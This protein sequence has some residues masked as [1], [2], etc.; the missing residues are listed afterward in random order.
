MSTTSGIDAAREY[1][2]NHSAVDE[3]NNSAPGDPANTSPMSGYSVRLPTEVL[4]QAR[5]LAAE[6]G[7]TTGAWLREAIEKQ[8]AAANRDQAEQSATTTAFSQSEFSEL[9]NSLFTAAAVAPW[10]D[11]AISAASQF[12]V[13]PEHVV[14]HLRPPADLVTAVARLRPPADLV[15][16]VHD[17]SWNITRV[18]PGFLNSEPDRSQNEVPKSGKKDRRSGKARVQRSGKARAQTVTTSGRTVRTGVAGVVFR[19]SAETPAA[20]RR[21]HAKA[22]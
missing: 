18:A 8:I 16:A 11:Q 3:I 10:F 19:T 20:H 21:R 13:F 5:K 6:Q 22:R 17:A 7:M 4:N 14:A 15:T 2:E 9:L 12:K 1:Y